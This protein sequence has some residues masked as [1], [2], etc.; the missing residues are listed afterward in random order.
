MA[1]SDRSTGLTSSPSTSCAAAT[2]ANPS[3]TRDRVRA[4]LTRAIYGQRLHDALALYDPVGCYWK[5]SQGTFLSG[6]DL[7]S[8]TWPR[9]G[10]MR[11]GTAY[12]LPPSAPRTYAIACSLWRGMLPT[13]TTVDT[14]TSPRTGPIERT[15][16]GP[17]RTRTS[18]GR[19]AVLSLAD[20]A[21][22]GAL[23]PTP[24]VAMATKRTLPPGE[25][26]KRT[27][28]RPS[29]AKRQAEIVDALTEDGQPGRLSP[30]FV[31]WMMGFPLDWT[32]L[33]S[34]D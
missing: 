4:S 10:T 18:D 14:R 29:G 20:L 9:S 1:T 17:L 31:E 32:R 8:E 30:R 12:P 3:L 2:R 7:F 27:M 6:L 28:E 33:D 5:T 23:L 15:S 34:E 22:R 21:M 16:P 25:T 13:P 24:R 11:S 26:F 19:S